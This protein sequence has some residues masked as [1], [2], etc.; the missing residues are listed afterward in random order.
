TLKE[1]PDYVAFVVD[2]P[3]KTFRDDLYPQYKANRPPM[4]DE[5]RAQ[6]Q[7]MCDIVHALGIDILRV[8]GVEADDVI[9]TLATQAADAG[10]EVT[11]STGDKDF[12]QLVRAPDGNGGGSIALVNTMTGSRMDSDAAVI[13]KFGVPASRIVDL[14]ALMGDAIDNVPGVEKCGPKTAAKWI[15]EYGSLEGVI[16]AAPGIKG[17]IGENLRAA[18]DRLPLN[19]ELVTIRTDVPLEQGPEALVLRERH[20]DQLRELYARYGFNQALRELEGGAV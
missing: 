7:P 3:G 12:A 2:A 15:G 8:D 10:M 18:L 1:K 19:R 17:K 11:I 14:L 13:D 16:A 6:V 9:G 4:P 5:L 20:V